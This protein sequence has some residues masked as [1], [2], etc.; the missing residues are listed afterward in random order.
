MSK[1]SSRYITAFLFLC[2]F[3][4]FLLSQKHSRRTPVVEVV[5]KVGPA[6]VN[7][8]TEQLIKSRQPSDLEDFFNE[9]FE[10]Y[11]PPVVLKTHSL[12]SGVLVDSDGF[13]ITNQH[14]IQRAS[15][16]TVV[17]ANKNKYDAQVLASDEKNDL[18]LLKIYDGESLPYVK[19]GIS[20]DIMIGETVI[21]LG[22]PFG[23]QNTVT[24]GVISATDRSIG[25]K[26]VAYFDDFLQTDAPINPGNSGGALLNIEGELIGINV[27]VYSKGQGL[28]FAIPVNRIRRMLG[29]LLDPV[30]L[31]RQ[32][33]GMDLEERENNSTSWTIR[34]L[35]IFEDSPALQ[36]KIVHGDILKKID[37]RQIECLFDIHK[38]I[39]LKEVGDMVS[40]EIL[41][42]QRTK[43]I[44]LKIAS[45]MPNKA[46]EDIVWEQ[47]GILPLQIQ[48]GILVRKL[49]KGSSAERIGIQPGDIIVSLE[50]FPTRTLEEFLYVLNTKG[51]HE[52]FNIVVLRNERRLGGNIVKE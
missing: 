8:S 4:S 48:G 39:Y 27:A 37:G 1:I 52:A 15:K 16:I 34:V 26:N 49:R 29:V 25:V 36:A 38:K 12:G 5:E 2:F 3:S 22:N 11:R 24:T 13:I 40:F 41:S 10:S 21:A 14:V 30:K 46:E 47:I 33:L 28:G 43:T 42:G 6:I 20:S 31:K 7:I 32:W 19:M 45:A 23:L 18:A 51:K 17:L 35:K 44:Q 50:N 9:F